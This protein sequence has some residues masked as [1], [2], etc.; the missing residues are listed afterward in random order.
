[1]QLATG[2]GPLPL[3]QGGQCVALVADD[4]QAAAMF[5]QILRQCGHQGNRMCVQI[6][7]GLLVNLKSIMDWLSWLKYLSIPR[8]GLEV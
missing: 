5:P 4:D 7:S 6:F 1:L 8:Y 2:E 3:A